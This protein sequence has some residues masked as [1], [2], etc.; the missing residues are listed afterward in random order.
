[1][2]TCKDCLHYEACKG[3]YYTA[4]GNEDILYDFD[5]EMYAQ[6]GCED[7]KPKADY[8]PVVRKPIKGYEG[9]YE[10]DPFGRV[11]S[12]DRIVPVEDNGRSYNKPLKG[13]Q[14]KQSLHTKGYKT[15][16]LTKDGKTKTCYVHRAVA[17]AFIDN[18]DNL[19]FINHK[20][21]DKTNN[22][23]DNLEWCT[24]E[25]N[26]NYGTARKRQSRALKGKKHTQEH[27]KKISKG[28]KAYFCSYGKKK[29]SEVQG[30]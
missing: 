10:V 19:P 2:S 15:V 5:G 14:M 16:S 30:E 9:Y 12:V 23:A 4:K 29:E 8:A 28:V 22:F 13:K 7:F 6:S 1:M 27:N 26:L 3:T 11:Y 18:P 20:D 17:E 21:E 24:N 25:Y